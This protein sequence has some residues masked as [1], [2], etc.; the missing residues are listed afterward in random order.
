MLK[1]IDAPGGN[2]EIDLPNMN[3]ASSSRNPALTMIGT[4]DEALWPDGLQVLA[5]L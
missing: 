1:L 4:I 2:C 3:F 5:A